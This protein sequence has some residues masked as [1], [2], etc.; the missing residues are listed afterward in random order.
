MNLLIE[1]CEHTG[2]DYYI[3]DSSYITVQT[4]DVVTMCIMLVSYINENCSDDLKRCILLKN[5]IQ[6][7]TIS[8]DNGIYHVKFYR[9]N[10]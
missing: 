10:R 1:F 3:F 6:Y 2:L 5:L 4:A 7:H 9:L 8:F